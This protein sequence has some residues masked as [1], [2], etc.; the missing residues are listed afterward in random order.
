MMNKKYL[1]VLFAI[2]LVIGLSVSLAT[3][4]L[5]SIDMKPGTT[6]T[7]SYKAMVSTYKNGKLVSSEPNTITN[8]GLDMIRGLLGAGGPSTNVSVIRLGNGTVPTA[9]STD[10]DSQ[11]NVSG[12]GNATGTYAATAGNGNWTISNT[13][14]VVC[15]SG[16][17]II[18]NTTGLFNATNA[19]EGMFAGS[20]LSTNVTLQNADQLTVTWNMEVS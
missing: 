14:T 13:Y 17:S 15:G 16:A 9:A 5:S 11:I 6:E 19:D 12:L 4:G 18:V 7:I 20:A 3:I 1:F 8:I 2:A 10:L